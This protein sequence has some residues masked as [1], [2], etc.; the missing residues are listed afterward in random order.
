M[1]IHLIS[2]IPLLFAQS[3][4]ACDGPDEARLLTSFSTAAPTAFVIFDDPPVSTPFDM[5]VM[6]CGSDG[7]E[8]EAMA[9]EAFMPAHQHGMNYRTEV[10]H[11]GGQSFMISKIVFH[12]PGRWE[13][14]IEA[15]AADQE[16]AYSADVE[17][18]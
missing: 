14:R 12:M 13:L 17:V 6:F 11:M 8:I 16:F 15:E 7:A 5:R 4:I 18:E 2:L 3:A 9:F 10:V 1:K